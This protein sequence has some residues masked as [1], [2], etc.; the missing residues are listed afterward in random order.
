MEK[1]ADAG[2]FS[3]DNVQFVGTDINKDA[4]Q[5]TRKMF[6]E[7]KLVEDFEKRVRLVQTNLCSDLLKEETLL[8]DVIIF[9]PV[10]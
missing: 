3:F 2:D 10:S 5:L 7:N 9:N 1:R 8:F 6:T 4:L